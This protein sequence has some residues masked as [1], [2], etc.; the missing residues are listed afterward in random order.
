MEY[1]GE[2]KTVHISAEELASY[3]RRRTSL[4]S[5]SFLP[6][7][8]TEKTLTEGVSTQRPLSHTAAYGDFY[9]TVSGA[10]DTLISRG[11]TAIVEVCREYER[12]IEN[13]TPF[14]S[15]ALVAKGTV[16][17]YMAA[18]EKGYLSVTVRLTF[19][20]RKTGKYK[21]FD[22]TFEREQLRSLFDG[23]SARAVPFARILA[24]KKEK[25][26]EE[27][28]KLKFPYGSPR[29][30]QRDF[31]LEAF[32]TIKSGSRL[33]V[34][35]PTGIGK[36]MAA[37]YPAVKSLA[38][39]DTDKIFYLTA[40]TVTGNAAA[41]AVREI[42]GQVT[43]LKCVTVYAKERFCP[44]RKKGGDAHCF[45]CPLSG[46]LEGVDYEE[47][48]DAALSEMLPEGN[49]YDAETVSYYAEKYRVCPYELSL[50]LSQWCDVIICDYNYAFD[51]RLRF[52]RYFGSDPLV[53]KPVFLVDEAHNLPDRAREMY[54]ATLSAARI[55]AAKDLITELDPGDAELPA[56]LNTLLTELSKAGRIALAENSIDT[57]EGEKA[58][59]FISSDAP[60]SFRAPIEAIAEISF[61][62]LR[63]HG[64]DALGTALSEIYTNAKKALAVLDRFD[65]QYR[66]FTETTSADTVVR[67][68]CLD[69]SGILGEMLNAAKAS[70][71]FSATLSPLPYFMDLLGCSGGKTLDLP[72]PYVSE[73]LCLLAADYVSTRFADRGYTGE[74]VAEA[75]AL[76]TEAREGHY[77]AYFPSY[78]FL[79]SV[80]RLLL[81][82]LPGIRLVVQQREM[83]IAER[84]RFLKAFHAPAKPGETVLGLCVLGGIFSEGIDL[85]GDS[86]IGAA[87][88][89]IGLGGL[90]SESNILEE[91]FDET[92]EGGKEYAYVYPGMNRILQAAG[93][94]I[95]SEED[96]G[97]VLLIDDRY[98]DPALRRLFPVH[99]HHLRYVGNPESLAAALDRFWET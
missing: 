61:R 79:K 91:Y 47:R 72:S 11:A 54:S 32:R 64:A 17:A 52:R 16:L 96:R 49:V 90:S 82:R 26:T 63:S 40:K 69:P 77:L 2:T 59:F 50:D 93:R 51:L 44:V 86:L 42:A 13:A 66:F 34:S 12:S 6:V 41:D 27:L 23:L 4:K 85:R 75:I 74:D 87:V 95:R 30:A 43:T 28:E 58:G 31:L 8:D 92:R 81:R 24:I 36:T 3:A 7:I 88:V 55:T 14:S 99:W 65:K 22:A 71:F 35:A 68:M 10:A 84:D 78:R 97:V 37:L 38:F 76:M 60:I 39:G 9:L 1:C 15:A 83:S 67:F 45:T 53:Q 89:G 19:I 94:V 25:G 18:A 21:S 20:A 29:E 98:N 70:I 73:N 33:L 46:T 48:R 5:I 80:G 56:A 57:E 62:K